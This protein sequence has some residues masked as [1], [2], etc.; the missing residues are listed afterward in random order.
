VVQAIDQAPHSARLSDISPLAR[1]RRR[2]DG[3]IILDSAAYAGSAIATCVFLQ[4]SAED[5]EPLIDSTQSSGGPLVTLDPEDASSII[6][7]IRTEGR[8]EMTTIIESGENASEM[9]KNLEAVNRP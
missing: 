8:E 6:S 7:R 1:S 2:R 4:E 3:E 5:K 9:K